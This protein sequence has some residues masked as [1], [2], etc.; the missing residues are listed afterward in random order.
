MPS[1]ATR[2]RAERRDRARRI[3]ALSL[4]GGDGPTAVRYLTQAAEAGDRTPATLGLLARALWLEERREDARA[5]LAD[6]L[7][8]AADDA[9]LRRLERTFR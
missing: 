8:Q 1:R 7:A 3:G 6:A 9:D 2:R 5:T 4:D